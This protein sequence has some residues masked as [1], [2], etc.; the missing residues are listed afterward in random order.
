[1]KNCSKIPTKSDR[2][3]MIHWT[4]KLLSHSLVT[5][6]QSERRPVALSIIGQIITVA[7][8]VIEEKKLKK[9]RMRKCAVDR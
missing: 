7:F 8:I 2:W 9:K 4:H 6:V 3:K 1:M 5:R